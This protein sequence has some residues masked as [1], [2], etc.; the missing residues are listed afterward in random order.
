MH[1]TATATLTSTKNL[2]LPGNSK[3]Q[4]RFIGPFRII[5]TGHS[6]YYLVLQPSMAAVHP[7][8]HTSLLTPT[9]PHPSGPP[10]LEDASYKVEVIFQTKKRGI[11]AKVK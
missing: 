9:G 5:F 3:F 6:A 4:P 7:W 8:F 10:A 1:Y 2:K 11:Y